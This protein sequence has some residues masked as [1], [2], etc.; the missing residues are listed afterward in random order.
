MLLLILAFQENYTYF[1][2]SLY[3]KKRKTDNFPQQQKKK[4]NLTRNGK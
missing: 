4:E 2:L 3:D 1:S